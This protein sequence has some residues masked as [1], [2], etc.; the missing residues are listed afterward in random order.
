MSELFPGAFL[1]EF[2]L[3]HSTILK[4]RAGL[5]VWDNVQKGCAFTPG[6]MENQTKIKDS[7]DWEGCRSW[8]Q[9]RV[10]TNHHSMSLW[11]GAVNNPKAFP[12]KAGDVLP[13]TCREKSRSEIYELH[14]IV[15]SNYVAVTRKYHL[16]KLEMDGESET[17]QA[18][19]IHQ[20]SMFS[21]S[22]TGSLNSCKCASS[23]AGL[24]NL[25]SSYIFGRLLVAV[26]SNMHA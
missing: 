19:L 6:I 1:A 23:E 8:L 13:P 5:T 25:D 18:S 16:E 15:L 22:L 3:L 24:L 12:R 17:H 21:H 20:W 2:Y 14:R 10:F 11:T 7:R 4:V 26:G 9:L